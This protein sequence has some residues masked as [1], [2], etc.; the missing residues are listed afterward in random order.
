MVFEI[1]L[2]KFLYYWS[3]EKS[4]LNETDQISDTFE[5]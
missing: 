3:Y 5:N 4:Q 1:V 2:C